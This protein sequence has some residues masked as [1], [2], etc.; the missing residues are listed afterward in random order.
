ME[1]QFPIFIA[2]YKGQTCILYQGHNG[3]IHSASIKWD[4]PRSP[5][6]S[7]SSDFPPIAPPFSGKHLF[8]TVSRPHLEY[9]MEEDSLNLGADINHL[10]RVQRLATRFVI[11]LLH[12]TPNEERHCHLNLASSWPLTFSKANSFFLI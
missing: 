3:I 8:R 6:P 12:H 7:S 5:P 9:A 4:L 2:V 11:G 10:K 1:V